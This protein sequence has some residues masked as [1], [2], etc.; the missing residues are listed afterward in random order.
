[1]YDDATLSRNEAT[2]SSGQ[3]PDGVLRYAA[4]R[5][6]D[7]GIL[8]MVLARDVRFDAGQLERLADLLTGAKRSLREEL[9]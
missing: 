7:N 4:A 3:H 8:D 1:M 5:P 2:Q 6:A 9:P